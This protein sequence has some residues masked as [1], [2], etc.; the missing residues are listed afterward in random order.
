MKCYV[1]NTLDSTFYSSPKA[2]IIYCS[3]NHY[4]VNTSYKNISV[5]VVPVSN[6]SDCH[7][8]DI[9]LKTSLQAWLYFRHLSLAC[10]LDITRSLKAF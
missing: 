5:V 6:A 7:E 10:E 8:S 1:F 4:Y 3:G 9:K 2:M